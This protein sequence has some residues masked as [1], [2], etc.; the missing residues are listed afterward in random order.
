MHQHENRNAP[1]EI[2]SPNCNLHALTQGC[3]NYCPA[4][5]SRDVPGQP[6]KI[7]A[8]PGPAQDFELVPLSLCPGTRQ[9]LLSLCPEKLHCPVPLQTL[10]GSNGFQIRTIEKIKILGAV[11]ELLAKWHRQF[12]Q[13]SPY[14]R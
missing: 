10:I 8:R 3:Q 5:P 11:L 12:G 13:S 4:V 6:V 2:F 9:K 1:S 7:P 14:I